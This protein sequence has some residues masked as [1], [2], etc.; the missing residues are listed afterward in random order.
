M[1][2]AINERTKRG[3]CLICNRPYR[4]ERMVECTNCM[5]WFCYE[6]V[7]VKEAVSLDQHWRCPLCGNTD[8]KAVKNKMSENSRL[9]QLDNKSVAS[10]NSIPL[11]SVKSTKSRSSTSSRR[12]LKLR[13][14]QEERELLRKERELFEE[15]RRLLEEESEDSQD[16]NHEELEK[17]DP[18]AN[19]LLSLQ[20][21]SGIVP[22]ENEKFKVHE[23]SVE[24]ENIP[25]RKSENQKKQEIKNP[26][27]QSNRYDALEYPS[28]TQ[29][30]YAARR[31]TPSE[32]PPFSGN[33]YDWPLF[34][35]SFERSTELCGFD[36]NENLL[37]LQ[38]SLKGTAKCAVSS[39]LMLPECVPQIISTLKML[40]GRPDQILETYINSIRRQAPPKQEKLE[41]LVEFALAVKNL[42]VTL[43]VSKMTEYLNNP[44]LMHELL[45]KL[46]S[47]MKVNWAL[48][49][50]T[51]KKCDGLIDF[52]DWMYNLA[53]NVCAA[54]PTLAIAGRTKQNHHNEQTNIHSS[55]SALR[56]DVQ[57][58]DKIIRCK[59]CSKT[60]RYI[61][62]CKQFQE[63]SINDKWKVVKDLK[64]CRL[65][66]KRHGFPCKYPVKCNENN[67]QR[68]HHPLLHKNFEN[69]QQNSSSQ[70]NGNIRSEVNVYHQNSSL[71]VRFR[72]L[73][74][75]LKNGDKEVTTFA[76]LDEGSSISM[77]DEDIA[78]DLDIQG[79]TEPLCLK[80]TGE[81]NRIEKNSRKVL[82][83]IMGNF[84]GARLFNNR[85]V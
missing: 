12:N 56:N 26:T 46:P 76:F 66:L 69:V 71:S 17:A 41:T 52:A 47:Q 25:H 4:N 54:L 22:N 67:C 39:F 29:H 19:E 7:K 10:L 57:S 30:Q 33:S 45:D 72:I 63:Y 61:S 83:S 13:L 85:S 79:E 6:C 32:L 20:I 75:T 65:C 11:R 84:T 60:C 73:P 21:E 70:S 9:S 48:H 77:V 15:S 35:S 64:L 51:L 18:L 62:D 27:H 37:R 8:S 38:K 59:V 42:C 24:I 36:N 74:V 14:L 28:L 3:H 40:F 78:K 80:W 16:L 34:I 2:P 55:E 1:G 58:H 5:K 50:S 23:E 31:S 81:Q 68:K 44:M 82:L 49:R 43:Q 53:T